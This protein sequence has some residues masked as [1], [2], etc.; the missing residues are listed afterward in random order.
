M[1]KRE[2]LQLGDPA[3]H[4]VCAGVDARAPSSVQ[5]VRDLADTL[6]AFREAHGFGRAIAAPQV[7]ALARVIVV[8]VPGGF[9]AA[10]HNPTIDARS[11]ETFELWDD[12][13]SFPELMV[14]V[15]R[16]V[17]VA[18]SYDDEHGA[19]RSLD[20][21]RD[22]SELLQ[23]EID[24]LDGVLATERAIAPTALCTRAEWQRRY[25]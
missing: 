9:Q 24:H 25:R 6:S 12:C 23:H 11:D 21:E 1:A 10:L 19:R 15:R 8:V 13:F 22:L 20:A 3:L 18:V 5:L 17:R 4:L 2:I 14:R 16:N 7:G